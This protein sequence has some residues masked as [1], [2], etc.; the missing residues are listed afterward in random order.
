MICPNCQYEKWDGRT[1]HPYAGRESAGVQCFGPKT[2]RPSMRDTYLKASQG[3]KTHQPKTI[4]AP[5][6]L[7]EKANPK[8]ARELKA[9]GT[10]TVNVGGVEIEAYVAQTAQEKKP[11]A[12]KK[13]SR[14][15]RIAEKMRAAGMGVMRASEIPPPVDRAKRVRPGPARRRKRSRKP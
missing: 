14:A 13:P 12:P 11:A 7:V 15:E 5:M 3:G 4:V 1:T 8:L 6:E 9:E 2:L 10:H